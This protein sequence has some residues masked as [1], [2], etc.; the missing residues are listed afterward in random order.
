MNNQGIELRTDS[1][2]SLSSLLGLYEA[3]GWAAYTREERRD[4]LEKAIE[5]SSFVVSAWE[6]DTLI[7]LARALSDDVSIVYLQDVLVHPNYQRRG[8][9]EQLI[10]ACLTRYQH[11]RSKV[12]MTDDE[13]RQRLFY[14]KAG[15]RN[16]KDLPSG[17]L[18]TFV[19]IDG[20]D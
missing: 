19:Q 14:E 15:F 5:N 9:G 3:V 16:T 1:D 17:N 11:V 13:E 6:G 10:Q 12:L 18:N 20:V 4:D 7:D 8:I 2:I